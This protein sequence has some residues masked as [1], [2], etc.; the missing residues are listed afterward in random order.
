MAGGLL[1]ARGAGKVAVGRGPHGTSQAAHLR[2]TGQRTEEPGTG[3]ETPE[4]LKTREK[5]G[6]D[7]AH[8]DREKGGAVIEKWEGGTR[9]PGRGGAYRGGTWIPEGEGLWWRA[10]PEAQKAPSTEEGRPLGRSRA[11]TPQAFR[12]S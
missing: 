5:R 10:G 4:Q 11:A 3:E 7:L 6:K 8:W 12:R 1:K 2:D 9:Q